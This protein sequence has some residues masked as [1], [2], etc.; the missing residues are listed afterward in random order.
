MSLPR[1]CRGDHLAVVRHTGG[2][3]RRWVA[4][5]RWRESL[6]GCLHL[7][8]N[9]DFHRSVAS[10]IE[11][12][13][14]HASAFNSLKARL[15]VAGA[16]LIALSVSATV[17]YSA[18]EAQSFTEQSII[19]SNLG[20]SRI[21]ATLSSTVIEHE[22]AL[23]AAAKSW[24]SGEP[25]DAA[26][27]GAFL[28]RQ[29]VLGAMFDHVEVLDAGDVPIRVDTGPVVTP[30]VVPARTRRTADVL[31]ACPLTRSGGTQVLLAGVL[32]LGADNFLSQIASGA[33]ADDSDARTV[34]ADAQ[35]RVLAHADARRLMSDVGDD[36]A[37]K[38]AVERWRMQGTPMEPAPWTGRL[39]D[40][41]VAMA[42]VP[43]TD[44]MVFRTASADALFGKSTR[45]I[46]RTV[47]LASAVGL[48]GAASIFGV[49]AW[50]L[51]P[52]SRLRR[53]ALLALD[54]AQPPGEG[55]PSASGEVAEL[56]DVL[57]HV[58]EQLASSRNDI[59]RTLQKMQAVLAHAPVGIAFTDD[60]RV[61]LAGSRLE[62]L[63]GY[64]AGDLTG[65]RWRE[66]VSPVTSRD[67]AR[68]AAEAA[69]HAGQAFE[70]ELPLRRR[71]GSTFW[72]H[73]QGAA[74]QYRN[75]AAQRM[76]W[77]VADATDA[78]RQR[79]K[80]EWSAAHDP[81]TD[82]IN[83]REF[84]RQLEKVVADRRRRDLSAA[85]FIDLDYFK[86]VNDRAGHAG[87]DMLLRRIARVL[88]EQTRKEDAVARLGGDE[89]AVLL[90]GCPLEQAL[91]IA[92]EIR[93]QVEVEGFCETD[94]S[95]RV[96]A[97]IGVVEIDLAQR[98]LAEVLEA[99][100]QACYAAKHAGRN[101]VRHASLAPLVVPLE[102]LPPGGG[103]APE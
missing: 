67:G 83:R 90:N 51:L 43:G 16:L 95:L 62:H 65:A 86:Q 33:Q 1:S 34:V 28:E 88:R 46:A 93:K 79:K 17:A 20:A 9:A 50:F 68:A 101:A 69:F 81:L 94:P 47:G 6:P 60:E 64:D 75:G 70:T 38:L 74:I 32:H 91:A 31:L 102:D 100:D 73:V 8:I 22:R 54:R 85:L 25:A 61:E 48:A 14:R 52:M 10:F 40:R 55:W 26:R 2:H 77:I 84:D 21:A 89:F 41:F 59:E 18:R 71:D 39:G 3:C 23:T 29:Q 78:R 99:A 7:D 56:S 15:A 5:G 76:I 37:L 49:T 87:G 30:P 72:A 97:S 35:G 98:S 66:L 82:L 12:V 45:S 11:P 96:T 36:P 58:S 13:R 103:D 27:I 19:D 4:A 24:P 63:L 42:A 57:K 80:L 44:W 92:Q 53:R